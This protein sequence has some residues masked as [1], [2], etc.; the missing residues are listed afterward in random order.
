VL[1]L[2]FK[3]FELELVWQHQKKAFPTHA[4]NPEGRPA[5]LPPRR[6]VPRLLQAIASNFKQ[7]QLVT[8]QVLQSTA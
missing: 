4:P 3:Q 2:Q 1:T 5:A 8:T 7:A 6:S